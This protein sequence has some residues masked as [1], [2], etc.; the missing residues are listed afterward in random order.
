MLLAHFTTF[1]RFS[2]T[3]LVAFILKLNCKVYSEII[4][5]N[6]QT[7]FDLKSIKWKMENGKIVIVQYK[8]KLFLKYINYYI[9]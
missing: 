2:L 6:L 3:F 9:N 4:N 7:R 8:N 1:F 5:K